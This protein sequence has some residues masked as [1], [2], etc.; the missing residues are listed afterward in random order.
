MVDL[1][2][3]IAHLSPE[4]RERLL[5]WL[6]EEQGPT[7]EPA[8]L[9]ALVPDPAGRFEPF[10]L[11]TVQEVYWAGRSGLYD[12]GSGGT[13][14]Y[15]ILQLEGPFEHAMERLRPA[16]NGLIAHHDMLRVVLEPSPREVRQRVLPEVPPYEIEVEDLRGFSPE[17]GEAA[18]ARLR[19]DLC[20]RLA[21][22]DRWPLFDVVAQRVG[23]ESTLLH[24]RF[25]AFLMD[26]EAR[27]QLL[28]ELFQLFEN[29]AAELPPVGCNYRDYALAWRGVQAGEL[30]RR[31]REYWLQRLQT[32]PAAP[33]LPLAR[34]LEPEMPPRFVRRSVPLPAESWRLLKQR[35]VRSGLTP[36]TLLLAAY[37][38][39][40]A[41]W[42]RA[43]RFT[44]CTIGSYRPPL[45]PDIHHTVGNFNTMSLL[46][47]DGRG[48]TFEERAAA[49]QARSSAD[50]EHPFFSGFEVLRELNRSR[51]GS[52]KAAFPVWFN[53]VVEYSHPTYLRE[54]GSLVAR[55]GGCLLYLTDLIMQPPQCLLLGTA[56]ERQDGSLVSTWQGMAAALPEGLFEAMTAAFG[57]LLHRLAHDEA[58]W[59]SRGLPLLP[60]EEAGAGT[61]EEEEA[62]VLGYRVALPRVE[63]RLA[64]HRA[65]R[66]AAVLGPRDGQPWLRAF[67]SPA[68]GASPSLA[69][70]RAHVAAGLPY[71]MVP[72]ELVLLDE[73]PRRPD[74][75]PD[76]PAL[77]RGSR[78]PGAGEAEAGDGR[79]EEALAAIWDEVLGIRPASPETSFFE[80]GGDSLAAVR[81]A[82]RVREKLGRELSLPALF[83]GRTVRAMARSLAAGERNIRHD[84]H[85]L[86][87]EQ[88]GTRE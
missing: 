83:Q 28:R 40:M 87:T 79:L 3:R 31:A 4:K 37:G 29:P 82:R 33:E 65:V 15:Q 67:V 23:E 1:A 43:R 16:L 78:G 9:P 34:E 76:R 75:L 12:L 48:A 25:E 53:S 58:A 17:A 84:R 80:L 47:V 52:S 45:H 81:L 35:G 8:A 60:E 7:A 54:T 20:T 74:G 10:P 71:Y 46:E 19:D 39:I 51:G 26:G 50:L 24:T 88:G 2:Q 72:G 77:D 56:Y 38:E 64:E 63:R 61:A 73:M 62:M 86:A 49:I 32:L 6:K 59:S 22:V 69:E 41:H 66:A 68:P 27:M 70:L 36:S 85:D 13:N 44:L 21:P 55:A 11:T 5:H 18:V 30:Y 57:R 14:I 42:G